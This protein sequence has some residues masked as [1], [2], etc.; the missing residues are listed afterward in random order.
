MSEKR[1]IELKIEKGKFEKIKEHDC[2]E[3]TL[4][5]LSM[6]VKSSKG[7]EC[8][9]HGIPGYHCPKCSAIFVPDEIVEI[10]YDRV[11]SNL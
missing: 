7:E 6:E 3:L 5:T 2:G 9:V 11:E 4:K 8:V 1:V 10:I